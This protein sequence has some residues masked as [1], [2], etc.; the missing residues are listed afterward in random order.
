MFPKSER[1]L[2]QNVDIICHLHLFRK[3]MGILFT[4]AVQV[5][6]KQVKWAKDTGARVLS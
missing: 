3:G 2:R 1:I 4:A 6:K 5:V